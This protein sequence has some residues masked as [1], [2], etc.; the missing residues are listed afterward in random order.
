VLRVHDPAAETLPGDLSGVERMDDFLESAT[1]ADALIVATEWPIYR[2]VNADRLAAVMPS[3]LVLDANRF[4]EPI[5]GGDARF[6]LISV[7]R[8]G[9]RSA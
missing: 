8:P 1:L 2:T 9:G 3:G 4:L 5:L 6:Q 7:G